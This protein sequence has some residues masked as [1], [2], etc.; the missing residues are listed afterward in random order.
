LKEG[1]DPL[2]KPEKKEDVDS[3]DS[4]KDGESTEDEDASQASKEGNKS[5]VVKKDS[6][7]FDFYDGERLIRTLKYK[8]PEKAGF[9]RIYWN[10][11]EKGADRPS[12][13]ISKRKTERGGVYVKP[14]TYKVKITHGTTTDET[15][16]TV[17]SDPRLEVSTTAINEIYD[18]GKKLNDYQ[19]KA[20][21]AV[22]QLVESKNIAT[23][24]SKELKE[25][26]K[27]K[28]K[29]QIKSSKDII[30]EIDSV[31]A[32]YLGKEDKRQG[33]TR[34]TDLNVI[35]RIQMAGGYVG[36]R[37]TGL[38]V[39]EQNL[40]RYAEQDLKA[41]LDKTNSFFTDKWKTYQESMEKAAVSPFKETQT[42]R[43]D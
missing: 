19:Q 6:V 40:I 2:K 43:L 10:M 14:G 15:M 9:H 25:A 21:D 24:F 29:D 37:Q 11:D 38:T 39:T 41:A 22:K 16:V 30:K 12:R 17:K 33:L 36:S 34:S 5:G 32:L 1:K 28:Y 13:R 26:D 4:N 3:E 23:K 7:Q 35:R 27:E 8:T 31:I 20:A 18:T 42:F